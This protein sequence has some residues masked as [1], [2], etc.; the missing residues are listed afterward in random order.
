MT[1]EEKA[2]EIAKQNSREYLPQNPGFSMDECEKSALE[3]AEWKDQQFKGYLEIE[4]N[5][6]LNKRNN[7]YHSDAYELYD[8]Q[9]SAIND[10]INKFFKN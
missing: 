3:M 5:N 9:A 6:A 4:L 10:I 8:I 1:N 2:I 7:A